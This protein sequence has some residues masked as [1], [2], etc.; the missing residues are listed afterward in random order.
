MWDAYHNLTLSPKKKPHFLLLLKLSW[1]QPW[2][3]HKITK[4]YPAFL[5]RNANV[6]II[7]LDSVFR[8]RNPLTKHIAKPK[9]YTEWQATH[10]NNCDNK[11]IVNSQTLLLS[12]PG[13]KSHPGTLLCHFYTREQVDG[14][15]CFLFTPVIISDS[16]VLERWHK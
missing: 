14:L 5:I 15:P 12:N 13:I 16:V 11:L 6:P 1:K 4:I 9:L 8:F 10:Q 3:L 2:A 7:H